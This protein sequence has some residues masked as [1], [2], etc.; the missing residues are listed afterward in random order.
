MPC[1][2][3]I[4]LPETLYA[5]LLSVLLCSLSF[6]SEQPLDQWDE[7]DYVVHLAYNILFSIFKIFQ[8]WQYGTKFVAYSFS[9]YGTIPGWL[10]GW[11]PSHHLYHPQPLS[12]PASRTAEGLKKK[13]LGMIAVLRAQD[14]AA[15]NRVSSSDSFIS[16][17]R[18]PD[19]RSQREE[20]SSQT[21]Y[22]FCSVSISGGL[23][24]QTAL[25]LFLCRSC[26]WNTLEIEIDVSRWNVL[27]WSWRRER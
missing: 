16:K 26:A 20:P 9:K 1:A 5:S 7:W 4:L 6:S 27:K 18:W 25:Q 11:R 13:K 2:S 19:R 3:V 21:C 17:P 24:S 14:K 10:D 22:M 12:A 23:V 8:F 15:C